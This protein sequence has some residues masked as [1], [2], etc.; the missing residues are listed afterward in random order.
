MIGIF[1][2]KR[3]TGEG[4]GKTITDEIFFSFVNKLNNNDKKFV[5][6]VSNDHDNFYVKE[7]K[8]KKL[9]FKK[10]NENNT[11]KKILIFISNLSLTLNY[12][13]CKTNLLKIDNFFKENKCKLIWFLSSE[14]REPIKTP[15]IA[16]V[17]DL[18]F[19]THPQF[20]EVGSF[21]KI[22]FKNIVHI[23]F[24]KNASKVITGTKIGKKQ[25][26]K[27]TNFKNRILILPHPVSEIFLNT[28]KNNKTLTDKLIK[29][30]YFLYPA[31][32]WQH[33]NHINLIK[34][35]YK[36]LKKNSE[37]K[38]VL[39]GKKENNFNNVIK[40]LN[41]LKIQ[42]NVIIYEYVS[43]KNLINLYDNCAAVTYV[44]FSGPEN[45][46]PLEA[47]ARKKILINSIYD[48]VYEQLK[49]YP[50]YVK[51]KSVIDIYNGML[52]SI[53]IK[54]KKSIKLKT[55]LDYI[56]NLNDEFYNYI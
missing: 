51:P 49:N 34:A 28:N 16:T 21:F 4:G 46:P 41:K 48:G 42:D 30:K 9:K 2:T 29:G 35:F 45:L 19:K 7:L 44:S 37:F 18:Q 36:F 8:R 20:E 27:F 1:L 22:L 38:L 50:I 11:L 14:Y 13:L 33:K 39:T 32:F 6:L 53:K 55:S 17:W 25:I 3:N 54:K 31:N 56:N 15:Y 40:L 24:I 10:I 23:N 5:F 52:R 12:L 26:I 43:T 47:I